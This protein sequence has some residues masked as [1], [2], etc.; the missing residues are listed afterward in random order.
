MDPEKRMGGCR[1]GAARYTFDP[2]AAIS[3][4]H[5]H[6][7]DCQKSTGSGKATLLFVLSDQLYIDGKLQYF[8]VTGT[9][10]AEVRRGF[11][12]VCGSPLLS[13]IIG[14]DA[15]KIAK[16]GSLDDSSWLKIDSNFW[17]TSA[18]PWSPADESITC[19]PRNPHP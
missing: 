13:Q 3:T 4:H 1:C 9:D 18:K 12:P 10:G 7:T 6:C 17:T 2:S 16:A 15:M 8:S 11:C 19:M 14:L 5:C